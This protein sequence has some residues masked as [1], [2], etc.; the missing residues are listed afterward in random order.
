MALESLEPQGPPL[1]TQE[2]RS[3]TVSHVLQ[4]ITDFEL[5][6]FLLLR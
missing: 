4:S 6:E 5:F 2:S 3:S 1:F